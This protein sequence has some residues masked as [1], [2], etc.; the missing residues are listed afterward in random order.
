MTAERLI[1]PRTKGMPPCATGLPLSAIGD[2]GWNL[3]REDLVLPLAVLREDALANNS[4]WMRD[5]LGRTGA[6]LAPHGKTTLSPQLFARQIADG[7]WGLTLATV[8]HVRVARLA[9]IQRILLANEP[10]G[11]QE[12]DWLMAELRAD[13]DFELICLVDSVEG[14]RRLAAA[15]EVAAPGRPLGVL[16][17]MGYIGGRCGCRDMAS[18]LEVAQAVAASPHLALRGVEGFEGLY[19]HLP[20]EEGALRVAEFLHQIVAVAQRLDQAGLFGDFPAILTAGGSAFYDLVTEVFA[21][22]RL[23][24]P[25]QVILRSGCYLTHDAGLY[26]RS[27]AQVRNRSALARDVAGGFMNALEVWAYVLSVPEPGRAILGAGRRDFGDDAA[28]PTAVH[29]FR[30]GRDTRPV[31]PPSGEIVAVNDQHAHFAVATDADIAVGDMIALG[32]SHPC[33]TFDKWRLIPLVDHTYSVTAAVET[34]F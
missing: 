31:T 6:A 7:A 32:V 9:G 15:A 5:F 20:A 23:V 18:A 22:A 3:L 34:F 10:V 27:F 8:Q 2:Q 26:D 28:R 4:R 19:Q 33:T 12:I 30:P 16:L 17:E 1:D 24:R 21:T 14:V 25:P 13:P 11:R 29:L